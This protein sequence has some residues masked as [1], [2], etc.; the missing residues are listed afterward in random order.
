LPPS[1]RIVCTL[2]TYDEV[3]NVL[4]VSREL[5]DLRPDLEVL[6]IDDDSPDGTWRVVAEAAETEPRLHLLHRRSERGRGSAGRDG[7]LRALEL[8]AEIVIEMDADGSHDPSS[9]PLLLERLEREEEPVGLVLGSRGAPGGRDAERGRWRQ[10]LTL[11]ANAYTRA[12]LGLDVRDCNSGF[13]CWR[14]EAL[15]AIQIQKARS[16]GPAIVQELLYKA[17]RCETGIAEVPIQFHSRIHGS[18]TLTLGTLARSYV[19]VLHLRWLAL[20]GRI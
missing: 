4:P 5:L 2:P 19:A 18:S 17:H 1:P 13:R 15:I 9:V 7:F 14:R 6:V 10:W 3:E 16:R 20:R 12:V 11:A 8:G